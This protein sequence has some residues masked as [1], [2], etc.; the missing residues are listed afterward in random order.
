MSI[1]LK[2]Y[3]GG[4]WIAGAGEGTALL[5]PVLGTE[6]A[7]ASAAGLDLA[8]GYAFAREQGG[9]GL[10]AM[11]YA[12]RGKALR[13]LVDV[14]KTHRARYLQISMENSGTTAAHSSP[15]V[16]GAIFTLGYYARLATELGDARYLV[17][18]EATELDRDGSFIAQH[19][20]VP[21]RGLALLINAFNFPAWGLWEKAAPALL[22]GVPVIAKPAT[23][24][25]WL[26]QAMVADAIEANVLPKGAL[27]VICG[28]GD[29]LLDALEPM[30]R[31]SF[32][33]SAQ[34][35]AMLRAHPA[36][37]AR[38]VRT[39]VEADSLNSVLLDPNVAPGSDHFGQFAKEMARELSIKSGQRC[40]APR[41]IFV[42]RENY[43][44]C[45][46]ALC[47]ALGKITVG[48]PRN[49]NVRM[50]SLVSTAQ[51]RDV[52]RGISELREEAEL[53]FDGSRSA[54]VDADPDISACVAPYLLGINTGARAR[55]THELE[56]FGPVCTLIGYDNVEQAFEFIEAGQGSLVCSVYASN[57]EFGARASLELAHVHGRLHVITPA[58]ST[59]HS[60]HGNVMPSSIHGGPGRA[61]GGEELGGLRGLQ[62]Y[63]QRSAIQIESD[64]LGAITDNGKNYAP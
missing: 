47:A 5:D 40:T 13:K 2:N 14:F 48:N 10:R 50:G 3:L 30:D 18:G 7:R 22:S 52:L 15:D 12:E 49:E 38:S 41:R 11:S 37:A 6:L 17:D 36:V 27:S 61:G 21:S 63:H 26:T 46:D 62:F 42:P 58:V 45:R 59:S 20:M 24:T 51:K 4:K 23:A 31:L 16:D 44:S 55:E 1:T 35:A 25:C 28:S 33:G 54:L 57:P 60:G 32:T 53:L 39:N 9:K 34:T 64:G 19:V 56:V 43:E 8:S 29:G